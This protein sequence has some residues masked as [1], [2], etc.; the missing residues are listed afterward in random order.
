MLFEVTD[1]QVRFTSSEV[2][3]LVAS[4]QALEIRPGKLA[5]VTDASQGFLSSLV[6]TVRELPGQ[7]NT[8]WQTFQSL[9]QAQDW[10]QE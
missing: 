10:L 4:L 9:S 8:Q 1:L 5:F 2:A 7:W 6:S 3:E